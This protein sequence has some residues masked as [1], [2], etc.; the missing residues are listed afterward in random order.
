MSKD[1]THNKSFNKSFITILL[2]LVAMI[3]A[4]FM[5]Y[6]DAKSF[7]SYSLFSIGFI[8]VGIGVLLGFIKMVTENNTE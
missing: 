8:L 5:F 1:K 2:G 4:C 3:I 7:L 6:F